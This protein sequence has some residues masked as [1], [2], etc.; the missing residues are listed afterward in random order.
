[1]D[2]WMICNFTSFSTVFQSYQDDGRMKM[3]GCVQWN[4]IYGYEDF[5]SSEARTRGCSISRPALNPLS[6]RCPICLEISSSLQLV[7][8]AV[9]PMAAIK[10][11]YRSLSAGRL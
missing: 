7:L 11:H 5:A 8:S 2:R 1:M 3:K 9:G 10:T 4:P 6:Y